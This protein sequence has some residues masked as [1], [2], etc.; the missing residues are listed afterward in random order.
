MFFAK[1]GLVIPL[2]NFAFYTFFKGGKIINSVLSNGVVAQ[3]FKV[4]CNNN[5]CA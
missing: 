5:G 1:N 4:G 3:K 2:I